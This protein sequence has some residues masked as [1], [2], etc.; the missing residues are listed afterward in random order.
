[1]LSFLVLAHIPLLTYIKTTAKKNAVYAY[2]KDSVEKQIG[3]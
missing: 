1:M 3:F 2:F